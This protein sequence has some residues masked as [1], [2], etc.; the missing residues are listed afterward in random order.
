MHLTRGMDQV[1]EHLPSQHKALNS[2]P[3][4]VKENRKKEKKEG[5][6]GERK[7]GP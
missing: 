3:S 2:N 6:K 7:E 4:N 1:V 5:S